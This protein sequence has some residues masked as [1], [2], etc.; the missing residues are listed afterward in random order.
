ML[1]DLRGLLHDREQLLPRRVALRLPR[2][3]VLLF[4]R[5][6]LQGMRVSGSTITTQL[7]EQEI[8]EI[9]ERLGATSE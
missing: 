1:G 3:R 4:P 7:N 9:L 8:D 6:P 5:G 2:L